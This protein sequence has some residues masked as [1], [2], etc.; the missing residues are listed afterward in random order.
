MNRTTAV[1]APFAAAPTC[2]RSE[3]RSPSRSPLSARP[4]SGSKSSPTS[5]SSYLNFSAFAKPARARSPRCARCLAAS[6]W[7]SRRSASR[8]CGAK[9]AGSDLFSGASIRMVCTPLRSASRRIWSSSTV[10][11][12]PRSPTIRTLFA[13]FPTRIRAIATL[14]CSRILSRPA[15]SGG[16]VP[17][18]GAYGFRTGSMQT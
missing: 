15:S 3:L 2:S 10:L 14:T 4:A 13:E 9:S 7:L 8:S 6:T 18:P 17:A 12:T 5:R 16:G 11:P 1:F